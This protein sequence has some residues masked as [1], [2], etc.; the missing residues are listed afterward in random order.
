MTV[1]TLWKHSS[2]W[3]C[4]QKSAFKTAYILMLANVK[5]NVWNR[6]LWQSLLW[7]QLYY[8]WKFGWRYFF[9]TGIY[10]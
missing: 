10:L 1:I 7:L 4:A 5:S 3:R 2:V 6:Y 8:F 9:N